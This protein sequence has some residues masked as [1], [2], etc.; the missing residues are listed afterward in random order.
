MKLQLRQIHHRSSKPFIA[1]VRQQLERLR[2]DLRIEEAHITIERRL[3]GSPAFCVHAQLVTPGPDVFASACDHTL[4][5]ALRKMTNQLEA[6]IAQ[7]HLR[8]GLRLRSN[9]QE[10]PMR[11]AALRA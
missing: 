8:R 2:E 7:R 6:K 11:R 9:L 4:Q 5:A 3:E 10:P 1:L